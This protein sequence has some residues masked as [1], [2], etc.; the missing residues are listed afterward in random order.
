MIQSARS[1]DSRS[2]LREAEY[3]VFVLDSN[4]RELYF[5]KLALEVAENRS[6]PNITYT[7]AKNLREQTLA[8][9]RSF[10]YVETANVWCRNI[11]VDARHIQELSTILYDNLK[12][13][14]IHGVFELHL[15]DREINSPHI[16]YVGT[17]ARLAEQIIAETIVS[18]GYEISMEM[19]IGR[20]II[21]VYEYNK[22]FKAELLG[23]ELK[24]EEENIK[25]K[26]S[27]KEAKSEL[28]GIEEQE[29]TPGVRRQ[30]ESI[31][32]KKKAFSEILKKARERLDTKK[33]SDHIENFNRR[34][35]IIDD[36]RKE[37]FEI[38]KEPLKTN[39]I[40]QKD[41]E[42]WAKEL[43]TKVNK[44]LRR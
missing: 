26:I 32:L 23:E 1:S 43:K 18:L 33:F 36:K 7:G 40:P 8:Y 6:N 17:E 34:M 4:E 27:Y 29:Y 41:T 14:N 9:L 12:N 42:S 37:F 25:E 21:P 11:T 44:F 20:K 5:R 39:R 16:Q 22:G 19:A 13:N 10:G 35:K 24:K 15:Q 38:L 31:E 3:A 2:L 28:F 30:L